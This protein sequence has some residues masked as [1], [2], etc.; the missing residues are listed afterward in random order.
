MHQ[1]ADF[2]RHYARSGAQVPFIPQGLHEYLREHIDFE[3][4]SKQL[5]SQDL[6]TIAEQR[7]RHKR[8]QLKI[9]HHI[10]QTYEKTQQDSHRKAYDTESYAEHNAH[11]EGHQS[12]SAKM[13]Q[14]FFLTPKIMGKAMGL[15]PAIILLSLSVWG[16]LLAYREAAREALTAAEIVERHDMAEISFNFPYLAMNDVMKIA[17]GGGVRRLYCC[18]SRYGGRSSDLSA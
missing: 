8:Y 9:R 16:T 3:H 15:N 13:I 10:E 18:R 4:I 7:G 1:V 2:V 11:D 17:K 14:D 5:T 12:L 6:R